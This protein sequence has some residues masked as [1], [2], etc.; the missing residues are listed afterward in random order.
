MRT[1]AKKTLQ[2]L[3]STPFVVLLVIGV[4][5]LYQNERVVPR[6]VETIQDFYQRYGTPPLVHSFSIN[7][8]TYYRITGEIAAPL[9]FPKGNPQYVFD[10]SGR[11]VDWTGAVEADPDFKARWDEHNRQKVIVGYFLERFPPN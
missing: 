7:G 6:G 5:V 11:L 3:I 2:W 4:S 10:F 1:H 9:A 8:R